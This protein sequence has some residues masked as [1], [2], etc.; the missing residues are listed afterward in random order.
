MPSATSEARKIVFEAARS[1]LLWQLGLRGRGCPAAD[2]EAPSHHDLG[3]VAEAPKVAAAWGE[4]R[5][6]YRV[7][8]HA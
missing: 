5:G 6:S 1:D 8:I 7:E 4:G 2:E 3:H